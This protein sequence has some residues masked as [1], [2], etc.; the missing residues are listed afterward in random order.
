MGRYEDKGEN[1]YYP[2][3]DFLS[4]LAAKRTWNW[5]IIRPNAI[6][7]FTPAGMIARKATASQHLID[8]NC[9]KWYVNGA[10]IGN[11]HAR[12]P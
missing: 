4:T 5:N 2:Q 6:I 10:H 11:L 8:S 3:E 12:L 7:G 9:R 1:F